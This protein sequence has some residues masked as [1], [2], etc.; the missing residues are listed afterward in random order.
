M[1]SNGCGAG[2]DT[3]A[4]GLSLSLLDR[5]TGLP[6]CLAPLDRLAPI[7]FLLPLRQSDGHLD[8]AVPEVQAQGHER[9]A[10]LGGLAHQFADLL[11]VQEELA[12]VSYTHLRAHE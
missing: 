12:P 8:E 9:H 7:V 4:P 10:A 11:L 2:I 1:R 3:T 6:V 5:C